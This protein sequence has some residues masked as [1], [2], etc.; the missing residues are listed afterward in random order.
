MNLP[1]VSVLFIT[2]KRIDLLKRTLD[3]FLLNTEY[4]RDKMELIVCDDGSPG[5]V[6]EEIKKL[7][8][9]IYLFTNKNEGMAANVNKGL[10]AATGDYI[11]QLQ[12]DWICTGPKN[13][14]LLGIDALHENN[15]LG[16][17]RYRLG[18]HYPH[19][20]S[21]FLTNK[22]NKI[23]ILEWD[24]GDLN[25]SQF[26]Y[27]DN[28][29]LKRKTFHQIIGMYKAFNKMSQTEIEFC[30]RFNKSKFFT[31]AFI[32]GYS[33]VFQ[34]IGENNSL[35]RNYKIEAVKDFLAK[36]ILTRKF[37]A[38]LKKYKTSLTKDTNV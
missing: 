23:N 15:D 33:E 14:L 25:I 20:S 37:Y 7:K 27:S 10:I 38:V 21:R 28:P 29:H 34:H 26:L 2:Y 19:F 31:V 17:I 5:F 13:Y 4:P 8:F 16:L 22:I 11:L 9:D 18:V 3:T 36:S 30:I 24:Q 32:E 1:K 6:Q 35:R 12:D